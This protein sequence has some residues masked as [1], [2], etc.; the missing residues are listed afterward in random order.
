MAHR[1]G[2]HPAPWQPDDVGRLREAPHEVGA[3]AGELVL[4]GVR[5]EFLDVDDD[6]V[7]EPERVAQAAF[8]VL[9]PG[10]GVDDVDADDSLVAG[11]LEQARHLEP[12]DVELF[13]D[14]HLGGVVEVVATCCVDHEAL[15]LRCARVDHGNSRRS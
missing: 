15:M 3:A 8:E 5:L 13:G 11:L 12:T 9:A 14:G 2:D 10:A 7:C 6:G 1:L 4:R